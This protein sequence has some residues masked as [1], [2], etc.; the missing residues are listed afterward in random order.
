M[1]LAKKC[2]HYNTQDDREKAMQDCEDNV[3]CFVKKIQVGSEFKFDFC[4]SRYPAGFDIV[5]DPGSAE[6]ICSMASQSCNVLYVKKL[7][8][9]GV[10]WR[11]VS[12]CHCM[13][14]EFTEQMNDLCI[15]LGDCGA[16]ANYVGTVTEGYSISRAPRLGDAYLS[17][18]KKYSESIPGKTAA[19]GD[20]TKLGGFLG[21]PNG[22]GAADDD[23]GQPFNQ[24]S[25]DIMTYG[26]M[27]GTVFFT[28]ASQG[29][30]AATAAQ[31]TAATAAGEA[32]AP[33]AAF[34]APVMGAVVGA[35]AVYMAIQA[36]GIAPGVAP[37]L[38]YFAVI[39][40]AVAGIMIGAT[41]I[42]IV[43]WIIALVIAIALLTLKGL[44]VGKTKEKLVEFKC[45]PWRQ[46]R[47]GEDCGKCGGDGFPCSMYACQSLGATCK[48]VNEGTSE[49]RCIAQ[50][51][52]DASPPVISPWREN[53][54]AG[55]EY[56]DSSEL[57]VRLRTTD[58]DGCVST[59]SQIKLGITLDKPG[60][61]RYSSTP[62]KSRSVLDNT[63]VYGEDE[64]LTEEQFA[65]D[66][67]GNGDYQF[68]SG[69]T[70]ENHSTIIT[71]PSAESLGLQE[72]DP[73]KRNDY[74][75]YIRCENANGYEAER[76]YV[77]NFCV[78][79]GK[80]LTAPILKVVEPFGE[81]IKSDATSQNLRIFTNEPASCRLSMTDKDYSLMEKNMNCQ[82]DLS[83]QK[84]LGWECNYSVPITQ[85]QTT[86]YAR[87]ADKPWEEND[88][89]KNK[90]E[91]SKQIVMKKTDKL[92][93]TSASPDN[94]TLTF[95]TPTASVKLEV[96][97]KGGAE[98]GPLCYTSFDGEHYYVP[99][100]GGG[101][102]HSVTLQSMIEG[103]KRMWFK[104]ED[105]VGNIATRI[106]NFKV[107]MDSSAPVITRT[108]YDAGN[109]IVKTNEPAECA[110]SQDS[111]GFN[112]ANGTLMSGTGTNHYYSV[113][114]SKVYFIRCKDPYSNIKGS[115]DLRLKVV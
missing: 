40:G 13:D 112:F 109:L 98:G 43:G 74:N 16:K 30:F 46:P 99:L 91:Q 87:C 56:V 110:L 83:A 75:I 72:Y 51:I 114:R 10:K 44:G 4:A 78:K 36:L 25:Q 95:G 24:I 60:A 2:L 22:L 58:G 105:S 17:A 28:L 59:F 71:M 64:E 86:L 80:D 89:S 61:C 94:E 26:G 53:L 108:Y 37:G 103:S 20:M 38:V 45:L 90:N 54:P 8:N 47:G 48:F 107:K 115:C 50:D 5:N 19:V 73:N 34:A 57:G 81:F 9:S 92:E 39:S 21:I 55:Y 33:S 69:I 77:I 85:A 101:I 67:V 88:T 65:Q 66:Y 62:L 93:I 49:E 68:S 42:P 113:E 102:I 41:S 12:N 82:T 70:K 27:I 35:A 96:Q 15:S 84:L 97:T 104:C 52:S 11:C 63:I 111:C 7:T 18:F 76:D 6:T 32:G 1:N 14:R 23:F 29:V 3:D 79:P 106:I 31:V 100:E